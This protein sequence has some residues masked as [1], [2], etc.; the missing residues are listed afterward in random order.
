MNVESVAFDLDG[1]L[2]DS[3]SLVGRILNSMRGEKGLFPL[4]LDR[5]RLWSSRG[6]AH[7][8][9]NALEMPPEDSGALVE[10]FR[11]RYYE[12]PTPM[13]SVFPG[14]REMLDRLKDAGYLLAICSNKPQRLCHKVLGETGLTHFFGAI[15][16]GDTLDRSKPNPAP[17]NHALAH[18]GGRPETALMVGDSVVDQQTAAA[19]N[20]RFAFFTGGYDDGVNGLDAYRVF[21][22]LDELPSLIEASGNNAGPLSRP[23]EPHSGRDQCP[24]DRSKSAC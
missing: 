17:L 21:D 4:H 2:I 15:V 3:A 12:L 16:G 8:V 22:T 1:T 7:L 9:G 18:L 11:G 19:A 14:A 23:S 13:D 20:V 5:Y 24:D 6:G 10:E